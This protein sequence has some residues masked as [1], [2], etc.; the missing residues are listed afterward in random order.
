MYGFQFSIPSSWK[1]YTVQ[2]SEYPYTAA[3]PSN[4]SQ[5]VQ[6]ESIA[7]YPLNPA[8][9]MTYGS[10]SNDWVFKINIA[11]ISV[12]S[13]TN[14][15]SGDGSLVATFL[16]KNSNYFFGFNG[17]Q[18]KSDIPYSVIQNSYNTLSSTFKAM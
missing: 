17:Q 8:T 2:T 4:N 6:I 9:N 14:D 1:G 12:Y 18:A 16:G 10:N 5:T 3:I 15:Q 7:F 13:A 11:P